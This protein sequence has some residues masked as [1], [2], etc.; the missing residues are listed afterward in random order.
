MNDDLADYRR[1]HWPR[2]CFPA[3]ATESEIFDFVLWRF[4]GVKR[5]QWRAER[6]A[7]RPALC[8]RLA[9]LARRGWLALSLIGR[10]LRLM[11]VMEGSWP[12]RARRMRGRR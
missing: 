4:I 9:V 11:L 1:R 7:L 12:M 5:A 3:R 8:L 10:L 6:R 2:A